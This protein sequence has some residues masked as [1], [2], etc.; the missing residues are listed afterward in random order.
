MY[1]LVRWDVVCQPIQQGGLGIHSIANVN[2]ALLRNWLWCSADDGDA[3]WKQLCIDKYSI[4]N[5][6]WDIPMV[7]YRSSGIWKSVMS[8]FDDFN[9][10]FSTKLMVGAG[11]DSGLIFGVA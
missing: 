9:F 6:G 4:H 8:I 1:H 3:L 10:C 7:Q 2:H 11:F 5:D